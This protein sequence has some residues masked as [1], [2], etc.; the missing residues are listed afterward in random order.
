MRM[1]MAGLIF[2]AALAAGSVAGCSK[3]GPE[4]ATQVAMNTYKNDKYKLTVTAPNGWYVM[5]SGE[6]KKMQAAGAQ[7]A[8]GDNKELQAALQASPTD[9]GAIF[10]FFRSAPGSVKTFN[11]SVVAA[12]EDISTAPEVQSGKDYF[13]HVR[14]LLAQ[15]TA[16]YKVKDGYGVRVI[17]GHNFDRM[18]VAMETPEVTVK[19][20]YYGVRHGD[21]AVVIIQ[22]FASDEDKAATDKVI[23][24]I[25]LDW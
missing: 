11:P 21:D 4:Y 2:A 8:A 3:S 24:S 19:Q 22:S 15:S 13:E 16:G 12:A 9:S 1:R 7:A 23:D 25:K 5:S 18:D 14:Q 20:I 17:G 6:T 10:S